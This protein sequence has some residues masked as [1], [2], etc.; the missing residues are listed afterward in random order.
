VPGVQQ[1]A[2]TLADAASAV[3]LQMALGSLAAGA[4][5]AVCGGG[6]TAIEAAAEL[7][8]ARPDL[9]VGLYTAG[10]VGAGLS[11][12]GIERLS[13]RLGRIGVQ[14]HEGRRVDA[15]ER[16]GLVLADGSEA[17][18][19]LIV[20]CGGF[21]GRS[22]AR[23]SG[24]P[25]DGRGCLLV[26]Q[27]LRSIGHAHVLGAGDAAAI[28]ALPGGGAY[29]MTCQAGMP[30]GAHAA[31]TALAAIKGRAPAVFDFGYIHQP[32]SLGRRDG[33]VQWVDRHDHPKDHVWVGRR[34][35]LYKELVTRS[36]VPS[37]RWE[38]RFPGALHWL[39]S[40]RPR[41]EPAPSF[42]VVH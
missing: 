25:T 23:D 6:L 32:I 21:V 28:P 24:L 31:D 16:G 8:T 26:D 36:A 13:W 35:A 18:A 22:L 20:W 30:A 34:A 10:T 7:A 33:V 3:R 42:G 29:R 15:V 11:P 37:I 40:G 38:R 1:H 39:S 27:A 14:T 2:H 17:I 5:V 4:T 9:T 19:D 41:T 12:L